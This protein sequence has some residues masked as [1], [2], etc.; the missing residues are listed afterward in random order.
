MCALRHLIP[1]DHFLISAEKER[2]YASGTPVPVAF[3]LSE[4]SSHL[5]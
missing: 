1:G 2:N 5:G 4:I 3:T